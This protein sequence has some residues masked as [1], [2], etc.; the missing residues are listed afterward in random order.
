MLMFWHRPMLPSRTYISIRQ[1]DTKASI[2]D[3]DQVVM[4][5]WFGIL[6]SG[7]YARRFESVGPES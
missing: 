3:T 7:V 4:T 6:K 5:A 1:A 2:I